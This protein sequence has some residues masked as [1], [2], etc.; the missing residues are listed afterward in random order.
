MQLECRSD[1]QQCDIWV[2]MLD[3]FV[4][5]C[6]CAGIDFVGNLLMKATLNNGGWS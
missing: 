4:D 1:V 6:G 3:V 2:G 5:S